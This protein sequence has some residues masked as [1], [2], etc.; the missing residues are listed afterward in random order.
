MIKVGQVW[1]NIFFP[2]LTQVVTCVDEIEK[3][4]FTIYK[5]GSSEK[6]S[7]SEYIQA[8]QMNKLIAAYPSWIEAVNSKEFKGE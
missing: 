6:H 4:V 8:L 7:V 1:S 5:D 3:T 2:S